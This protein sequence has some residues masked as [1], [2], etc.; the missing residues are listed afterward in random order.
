MQQNDSELTRFDLRVLRPCHENWWGLFLPPQTLGTSMVAVVWTHTVLRSAVLACGLTFATI[1][2]AAEPVRHH[3]H[4]LIGPVKH[5]PD[6]KNFSWVNPQAPKGGVLH[7]WAMGSFD[8]L[9]EF[10]LKGRA[11]AG[12]DLIYDRLF[13]PSP[14]EPTAYYGLVAE[15]MSYPDD[16]GSVTVGLRPGAKFHDGEPVK[17]EDVI[18]SMEAIKA[19]HPRF[20]F[21]YKNVVKAEKTG[22]REVTF[23]FDSK[24]NRELPHIVGELHVLPK[25]FWTATGSDGQPRS[26]NDGKLEIP[27]GSGPYR[28]KSVETGR[29]ISYERVKDY[30]AKDLPV[31]IGQWNFDEIR[32]KYYRDRTPAFEDFKSGSLDAWAENRASAWATQYEFDAVKK[33]F[34]KKEALPQARVSNMQAFVMN[35]RKPKFADPRVRHAF[36]LAFNFEDANR[37]LFYESYVRTGSYFD[38]SELK[39]TGVPLGRELEILNEVKAEVPPEVFTTEYKNPINTADQRRTNLSEASKLLTASGWTQKNGHLVNGSGEEFT[40]EFLIVSDDMQKIILPYIEDLKLLG[41]KSS[42]RQVD[43]AQYKLREDGRDFDIVVDNL[44]QSIS[45]GN[46]QR[47]FWSSASSK[48]NGSR[49]T[50]GIS[51]PGVD[52]LV[53]KVVFATDRAELVAATRALDRVLLWNHYVVP[54]WH[55]PFERLATWDIFGRPGTLPS[56]ESAF[57]RVWW[58]DSAKQAALTTVRAK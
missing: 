1:A 26:L 55:Y 51:N 42:I 43:D 18:F 46:E 14:D 28:V 23:T 10:S 21:Y 50:I 36:N 58:I 7:Q 30:W 9:N 2:G 25:H 49:N 6:Y 54:Q 31:T 20:A 19:A 48:E 12:L 33:G 35:T 34:V 5:G 37:K 56:Q 39:A 40:V 32:F 24:G 38:N 41:I 22:D 16:F 11:A 13:S 53:D 17:P 57:L 27:L 8:S 29:D 15:W 3:G 44:S 4:S 45:P 47:D 52:K